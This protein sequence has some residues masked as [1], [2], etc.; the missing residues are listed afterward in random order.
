MPDNPEI[1]AAATGNRTTITELR[2]ATRQAWALIDQQ[3]AQALELAQ[4]ALD[5]PG[6]DPPMLA[7]SHLIMGAA[8]ARLGDFQAARPLLEAAQQAYQTQ[9]GL[10][11]GNLR[12]LSELG[13]CLLALGED[14]AALDLLQQHQQLQTTIF[15][16][17]TSNV[18]SL[19]A[20]LAPELH[21]AEQRRLL[22]SQRVAD[23]HQSETR[24]ER[25]LA[26]TRLVWEPAELRANLPAVAGILAGLCGAS[27]VAL[28]LPAPDNTGLSD[29]FSHGE[30]VD[31]L[32]PALTIKLGPD[33]HDYGTLVV[34]FP[35][36]API[37]QAG[38]QALLEAVAWQIGVT[39]RNER[40]HAAVNRLSVIDT[41]TGLYN[42][43][44]FITLAEQELKRTRRYD[45]PFSILLMDLDH[46]KA[47]NDEHG[48][49]VGD[50]LLSQF[51]QLLQTNLRDTDVLARY[52]GEEFILLL[53]E[54]GLS[55]ALGVAGR[56]LYTLR[57]WECQSS[58]GPLSI[59][60]SIGVAGIIE[61]ETITL[62]QL[63]DRADKALYQS[64]K[65]GRNRVT[66]WLDT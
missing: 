5:S 53:P 66:V 39:L 50:E 12:L 55:E 6:A 65:N 49:R 63:L 32:A 16:R 45:R 60:M 10:E 28:T 40:L 56:L 64:K 35:E 8:H 31:P 36:D 57:A 27:S 41:L 22:A 1:P 48:V 34:A 24:A 30:P 20:E 17:D 38:C 51:A 13:W 15:S 25:L 62:D 2:T 19:Q 58:A 14:E 59:T 52:G 46:F 26:I 18:A 23:R 3:P 54:T 21:L 37:D 61:Q 11:V 29:T 9:P 33:N 43:R 7:F 47:I 42:R 44:Y 4:Q